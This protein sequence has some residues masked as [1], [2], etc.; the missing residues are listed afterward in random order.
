MLITILLYIS[1]II[2]NIIKKNSNICE[3]PDASAE[4]NEVNNEENNYF[5]NNEVIEAL[6]SDVNIHLQLNIVDTISK[7]SIVIKF[8]PLTLPESHVQVI[9]T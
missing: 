9:E 1:N 4:S 5:D 8:I 6:H 7:V 2:I 3:T